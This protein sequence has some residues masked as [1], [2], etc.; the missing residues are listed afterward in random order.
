MHRRPN[1]SM[2]LTIVRK[3]IPSGLLAFLVG[4]AI[5]DDVG[6]KLRM[7]LEKLYD[8]C[9]HIL[10]VQFWAAYGSYCRASDYWLTVRYDCFRA[11]NLKFENDLHST[12][13]PTIRIMENSLKQSEFIIIK[14][15][16]RLKKTSNIIAVWVKQAVDFYQTLLSYYSTYPHKSVTHLSQPSKE[17]VVHK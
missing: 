16:T 15:E 14:S 2:D 8:W 9:W 3:H 13:M 10:P 5:M 6:N 17:K 12:A 7:F 11:S 1:K 4:L